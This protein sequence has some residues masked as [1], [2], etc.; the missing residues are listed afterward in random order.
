MRK[1]RAEGAAF[2][3]AVTMARAGQIGQT[4]WL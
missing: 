3:F 2:L 4:V 1:G